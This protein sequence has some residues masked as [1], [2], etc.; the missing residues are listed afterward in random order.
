M[1]CVGS[2]IDDLTNFGVSAVLLGANGVAKI[3]D[4]GVA[5]VF[6]SEKDEA[7]RDSLCLSVGSDFLDESERSTDHRYLSRRESDKAKEMQSQ[8]DSGILSKTEG[9]WCFWS[10]EMCGKN[11]QFSG[12]SADMWAAG[13]C[14][15]IFTT[16]KIPFFSMA[17]LS[18][19]E[20]IAKAEVPYDEHPNMS[21]GLKNLLQNMLTKNPAERAGVGFCLQH[22]FC[23]DARIK[24]VNELGKDF[25]RSDYDIVLSNEEVDTVSIIKSVLIC[26]SLAIPHSFI[27]LMN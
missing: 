4:F 2:T 20:M 25:D 16:G 17:P 1:F 19:F 21:D 13:I 8:H 6:D 18:L 3:S 5:H 27:T 7:I 11:S 26:I 12:Y 9:T 10:P 15:F 24:R 14:L 23:Q 22:E